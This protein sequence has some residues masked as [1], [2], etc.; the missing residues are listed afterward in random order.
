MTHYHADNAPSYGPVRAAAT[1]HRVNGSGPRVDLT[2]PECLA[3][4]AAYAALGGHRHPRNERLVIVHPSLLG[5]A[6][7]IRDRKKCCHL[8]PGNRYKPARCG[9]YGEDLQWGL[10]RPAECI[11]DAKAG[12]IDDIEQLEAAE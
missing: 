12:L 10:T 6:C 3:A 8:E 1:Y 4:R 2:T 9:W 7:K 11:R 5:P